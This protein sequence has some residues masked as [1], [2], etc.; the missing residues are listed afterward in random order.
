M[1][2]PVVA[3]FVAGTAFVVLLLLYLYKEERYRRPPKP[4]KGVEFVAAR[5]AVEVRIA[6]LAPEVMLLAEK[7]RFVAECLEKGALNEEA[8]RTVERLL[9]EAASGGFWE[10]FA[11]A[12]ALADLD[13]MR[14]HG[15]FR[16]LS[17]VVETALEMLTR[18][19]K[20]AREDASYERQVW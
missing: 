5:R 20:I 3:L 8:R 13:P 9:R 6:A 19:E 17:P 12:L 2:W 7:E 4:D 11:G 10:R 18:A 1:S 14:A 16:R 15:E